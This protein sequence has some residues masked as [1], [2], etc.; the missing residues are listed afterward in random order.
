MISICAVSFPPCRKIDRFF[1]EKYE[2]VFNMAL[3]AFLTQTNS[4]AAEYFAKIIRKEATHRFEIVPTVDAIIQLSPDFVMVT[5]YDHLEESI[6][7]RAWS[8]EIKKALPFTR[9]ILGGPAFRSRPVAYF[10][11]LKADYALRGEADFTFQPLVNEITRESPDVTAL[12][13]IP[14]VMF[15]DYGRLFMNHEYPS[16]GRN[17]LEALDFSHYC[18]YGDDMVSVFTERG[19]PYGCTYCSRVFGKKI[20]FLSIDKIISI[21]REVS[22]NPD[23]KRVIFV[24]DNMIY[25]LRRAEKLF[26]KIIDEK[27]NER[28]QFLINARVD[29][30]ISHDKKYLP[31][32][33]NYDL[34]DLLKKAG[35]I[36]ISFGTESFNDAEIVRLKPEAKYTGIDAM[37]LTRELGARG[38]TFIHFV[39]WPSPDALPEEAIESACKRLTVMDSYRDYIEI[40]PVFANPIKISLIRGSALYSRA[41]NQDFQVIDLHNPEEG[42]IDIRDVENIELSL[43]HKTGNDVYLPFPTPVNLFGTTADPYYNLLILETE[44]ESLQV[45]DKRSEKEDQRFNKLI[46]MIRPCRR[47]LNR[48]NRIIKKINDETKM[49]LCLMLGEIGGVGGFLREYSSLSIDEKREKLAGFT[50]KFYQASLRGPINSLEADTRQ[51]FYLYVVQA[52]RELVVHPEKAKQVLRKYKKLTRNIVI[53]SMMR[54]RENTPLHIYLNYLGNDIPTDRPSIK[55]LKKHLNKYKDKPW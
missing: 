18:F 23:V 13:K 28:F 47:Q 2:I 3:F 43:L 51:I 30:F 26:G 50:G 36:K 44:L 11:N 1:L 52:V 39:I 6:L 31:H 42:L 5:V 16:L 45:K 7:A 22:E 25:N 49:Q 46:R 9:I 41:L 29:N 33:I 20:R 17:Q 55:V 15:S 37:R 53:N 14:G 8:D 19:C 21:L 12:K 48:I 40:S 38:I 32:G 10:I 34:M 35:V 24:N 27:L 54:F 4:I